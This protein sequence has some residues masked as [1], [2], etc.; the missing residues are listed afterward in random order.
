MSE[1]RFIFFH[2]YDELLWHGYEKNGLIDEFA[3]V[4]FCQSLLLPE[5][6]KFNELAKKDGKLFKLISDNNYPWY[7]DRLQGGGYIDEYQYNTE[8]I[9][10]LGNFY[11]FQMHEWI[12]NM[13]SDYFKLKNLDAAAWSEELIVKEI[14]RLFPFKHIFLEAATAKE[15]AEL[16]PVPLYF[17]QLTDN[18]RKLLEMRQEITSGQLLPCDSV[19]MA[20]KLEFKLG[21]KRIMPEI[22]AQTPRTALYC[23]QL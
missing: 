4:R 20:P 22:G 14:L 2:G 3:G 6:K 16:F 8:L 19:M 17:E 1:N 7:I 10:S 13:R 9:D 11:G 18:A 15:Y 21:V 12:S 5:R 23:V